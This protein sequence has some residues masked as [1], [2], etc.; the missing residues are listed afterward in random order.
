[1]GWKDWPSW[2]KGGVIGLIT[3]TILSIPFYFVFVLCVIGGGN[4]SFCKL[5]SAPFVIPYHLSSN[6]FG[7]RL[8]SSGFGLLVFLFVIQISILGAII[9]L[10]VGKIRN[11]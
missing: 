9:G 2:V 8:L 3:G 10:I 5:M 6:L 7:V 1:M 11:K 4:T